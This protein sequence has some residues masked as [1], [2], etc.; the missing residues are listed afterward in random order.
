MCGGIK[1]EGELAEKIRK[2][3]G[4]DSSGWWNVFFDKKV[5]GV[6]TKTTWKLKTKYY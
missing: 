5:S 4:K 3:L 2:I 6:K 1:S